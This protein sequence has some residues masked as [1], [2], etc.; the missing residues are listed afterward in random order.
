MQIDLLAVDAERLPVGGDGLVDVAGLLVERAHGRE[1]LHVA[2]V[3]G[4]EQGDELRELALGAERLGHDQQHL[5]PHAGR[6]AGDGEG[7][8]QG[9]QRLVHLLLLGERLPE[10]A[11]RRRQ[12]PVVAR[13]R[14]GHVAELGLRALEVAPPEQLPPQLRP[15]EE[16]ARP[17]T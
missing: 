6:A 10:I 9:G 8:L 16:R 15:D 12:R 4:L 5:G 3:L 7:P 2:G 14:L 1:P 13:G 17:P 11:Q